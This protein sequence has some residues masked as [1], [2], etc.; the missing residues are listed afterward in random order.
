MTRPL[1]P[2]TET[3]M[4]LR[5]DAEK[6]GADWH[7]EQEGNALE[8]LHGLRLVTE[9]LDSLHQYVKDLTDDQSHALI[10]Q[11]REVDTHA[12]ELRRRIVHARLGLPDLDGGDAA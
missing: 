6:A 3:L 5:A 2:V 1:H 7:L 12:L 10:R 4:D 11:A 9:T 8:I